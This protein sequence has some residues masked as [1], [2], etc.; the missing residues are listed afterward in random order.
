MGVTLRL[1]RRGSTNN[2]KWRFVAA[3]KLS[4]RDGGFIELLGHYDPL[5]H[6]ATVEVKADRVQYWVSEGAKATASVKSLLKTKG[7][8]VPKQR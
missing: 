2:A 3:H 5:T 7:I 1:Q 8:V 6:P 4:K